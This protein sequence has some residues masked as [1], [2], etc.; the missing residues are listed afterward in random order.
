MLIWLLRHGM[1]SLGEEKRYQGRLDTGLSALGRRALRQAPFQP[2]RLYISPLLRAEETAAILFP[3]IQ[4]RV[5][6]DLREMDFGAFEG[7]NWLELEKDGE[8]R[9]WVAG[10]CLGPCPDGEDKAGY[11]QRVCA[12][13]EALVEESLSQGETEIAVVAHGGTQMAVLE[14][15]GDDPREYWQWQRAYG[16]GWLLDTDPWPERLHVREEVCLTR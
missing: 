14:R 2:G 3:E 8:Y 11:T 12:A 5:A 9:T 4:P 7:K 6:A 1:T 10:G 13:F 15:W 16:C